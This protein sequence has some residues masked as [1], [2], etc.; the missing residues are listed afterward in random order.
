MALVIAVV[1]IAGWSSNPKE[2]AR[3]STM[4]I[5]PV[6]IEHALDVTV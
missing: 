5:L 4:M 2:K 6:R 3:R 1:P